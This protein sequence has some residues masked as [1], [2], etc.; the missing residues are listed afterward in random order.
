MRRVDDTARRL[1]RERNFKVFLT[2]PSMRAA[3]FGPV[4]EDSPAMGALAETALVAQYLPAPI[5]RDLCF[6]RW[7]QGEVD[8][9]RVDQGTQKPRWALDVKWSDR[10][11][12][13]AEMWLP[14]LEFARANGHPK[15]YMTARTVSQAQSRS[16]IETLVLPLPMLCFEIGRLAARQ[17]LVR[18]HY[19]LVGPDHP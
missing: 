1:Q 5:F 12:E 16:G 17:E 4:T 19:G 8:L 15:V 6:A 11:C 10:A 13:S 7:N 18:D 14:L 2:N 9:V 3:L